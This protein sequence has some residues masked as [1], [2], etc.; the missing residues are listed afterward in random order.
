MTTKGCEET[1]AGGALCQHA[2]L[3]PNRLPTQA[4]TKVEV[5]ELPGPIMA[6]L[7]SKL[8]VVY[9]RDKGVGYEQV[10]TLPQER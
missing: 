6:S 9:C 8:F 5:A 7:M 10:Q 1:R 4:E 2:L 3:C